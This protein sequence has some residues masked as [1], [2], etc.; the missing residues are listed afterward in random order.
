MAV[1]WFVVCHMNLSFE[2]E[3]LLVTCNGFNS[4][5]FYFMDFIKAF[6]L[7]AG[8]MELILNFLMKLP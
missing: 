5:I 6:I 1:V 3:V 2:K 7:V 4:N 8:L